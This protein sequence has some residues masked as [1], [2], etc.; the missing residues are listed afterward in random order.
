MRYRT[1]NEGLNDTK[2]RHRTASVKKQEAFNFE[3]ELINVLGEVTNETALMLETGVFYKTSVDCQ[4]K[5][6]H[7]F[8]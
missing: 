8:I 1:V 4:V 6:T 3:Y 2:R 5:L 7:F